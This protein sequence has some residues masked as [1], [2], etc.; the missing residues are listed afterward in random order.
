M[1]AF[2]D[3]N[4]LIDYL[5]GRAKAR[6]E[7]HRFPERAI[8]GISWAETMVGARGEECSSCPRR[9]RKSRRRIPNSSRST[10]P[11]GTSRREST[12][13]GSSIGSGSGVGFLLLDVG[14]VL[15]VPDKSVSARPL[16]SIVPD[17]E[18]VR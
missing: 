3:T 9:F 16:S 12:T 6:D 10:I 5:N 1:R 17:Q 11:S 13:T 4:I 8:S 18:N 7:I 15:R 14:R 2:F